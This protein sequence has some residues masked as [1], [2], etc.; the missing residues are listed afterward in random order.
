MV[1][2]EDPATGVIRDWTSYIGASHKSLQELKIDY[3]DTD[4]F[5]DYARVLDDLNIAMNNFNPYF[6]E[7]VFKLNDANINES[8]KLKLVIGGPEED[9]D[10]TKCFNLLLLDNQHSIPSTI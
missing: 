8:K 4:S 9:I 6:D 5:T 10:V 1:T 7:S 2:S 3:T